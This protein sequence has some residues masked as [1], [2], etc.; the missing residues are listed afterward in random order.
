MNEMREAE[1]DVEDNM[2][3]VQTPAAE[4]EVVGF[5]NEEAEL[6][7]DVPDLVAGSDNDSDDEAEDQPTLNNPEEDD[8]DEEE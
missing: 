6:E 4:N 7:D 2:P 8:S 5:T 1:G 3:Q